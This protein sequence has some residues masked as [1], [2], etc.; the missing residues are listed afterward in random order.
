[1]SNIPDKHPYLLPYEGKFPSID[2]AAFIAQNATVI[3]DVEIG[4][5]SGIW[6]GC[7]IRGDVNEIRIGQRT[8]IQ[9]LTMIHCAELGQGTYL[10]DDI[11]VG[12]SA[13]LHACSVEDNAFIGIQAC[14]MDDCIVEAGAMVAAGALVTPGKIVKANEVWAG[15]PA[16]KLRDINQKDLQ[17]FEINRK[18]YQR[19]ADQYRAEQYGDPT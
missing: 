15:R 16:K 2:R 5:G 18:R 17:F 19:L 14:V 1:M 7:V 11:T 4:A 12:H 10:G 3:G 9:D 6:Y 13:V 8:N